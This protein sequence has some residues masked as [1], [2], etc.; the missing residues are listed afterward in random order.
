[1]PGGVENV[2]VVLNFSDTQQIVEV[3]FPV[4]AHWTDRLAGF[5]GGPD[6]SVDVAGSAAPVP[7][8]SHFGRI[9]HRLNPNP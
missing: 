4:P 8:G 3:P 2:V 1:M 6:W 5:S 9:F 7:V